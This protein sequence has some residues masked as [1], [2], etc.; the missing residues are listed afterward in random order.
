M[1][2]VKGLI[3]KMC[4]P[5]HLKEKKKWVCRKGFFFFYFSF[6]ISFTTQIVVLLINATYKPQYVLNFIVSN[7]Y[8]TV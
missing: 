5:C 4:D 2:K 8:S 3:K 7:P 1:L 6:L